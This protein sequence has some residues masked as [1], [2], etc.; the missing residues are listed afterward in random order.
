MI[1][2]LT[3]CLVWFSRKIYGKSADKYQEHGIWA[4]LFFFNGYI[5]L[6][7]VFPVLNILSIDYNS[8]LDENKYNALWI[9]IPI[10]LF[11]VIYLHWDDR[12]LAIYKEIDAMDVT[13]RNKKITYILFGL[14]A[15]TLLSIVYQYTYFSFGRW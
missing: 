5:V 11:E 8:I 14:I 2:Y 13:E 15:L 9:L 10:L 3:Y 1:K 12:Y 4:I 6:F 7:F